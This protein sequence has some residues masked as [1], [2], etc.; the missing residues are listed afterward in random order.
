[1][2]K[3]RVTFPTSLNDKDEALR[4]EVYWEEFKFCSIDIFEKAINEAIG[5]CNFFPKP[6]ELR[7]F[8]NEFCQLEYLKNNLNEQFF[9]IEYIKTKEEIQKEQEIAKKCLDELHEK[10]FQNK[11]LSPTLS[12]SRAEE[13]EIKRLEAKEKLKQLN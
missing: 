2:R 5:I 13:F 8:I 11:E 4:G 1:M 10:L 12:P 7:G 3:L 9:Q 6:I